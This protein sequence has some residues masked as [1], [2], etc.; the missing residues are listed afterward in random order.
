[1]SGA[2]QS[3]G[4]ERFMPN[5]N[6]VIE[7]QIFARIPVNDPASTDPIIFQDNGNEMFQMNPQLK[8]VDSMDL[9]LTDEF[10]RSLSEVSTMQYEDGMLNYTVTLKF[11]HIMDGKIG[12]PHFKTSPEN[13]VTNKLM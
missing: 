2:F 13:L 6:Q 7:S 10:G 3:V 11:S 4:H 8:S 5:G 12:P 1:M 9:W